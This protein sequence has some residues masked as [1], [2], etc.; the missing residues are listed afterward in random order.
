MKKI[1]F[2][3][4]LFASVGSLKAQQIY[5]LD[6][7]ITITITQVLVTV[8]DVGDSVSTIQYTYLDSAGKFLASYAYNNAVL[9]N[10]SMIKLVDK[11]TKKVE[12]KD[13]SLP[14]TIKRKIKNTIR[15]NE[16]ENSKQ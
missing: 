16:E 15:S 7:P 13:L 3:I 14:F 4:L 1:F 11:K 9:D 2:L 8:Q 6:K 10:A 12:L 5:E